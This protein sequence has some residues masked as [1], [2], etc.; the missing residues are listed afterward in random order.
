MSD[1][2][3][4]HSSPS[5]D[6]SA[7]SGGLASI[8]RAFLRLTF[9][10]TLLSLAGVFTGGV[11]LYA[12]LGESEAVRQQTAATVWPYV[13]LTIRDFVQDDE[14]AFSL[15]FSNSGVGP[16]KM[17]EM[18]LLIDG[19]VYRD[20][21][22]VLTAFLDEEFAQSV[23]YGRSD[24]TGRVL[25]PGETLTSF[26]TNDRVVVEGMQAGI[27]SGRV[28]L[29]YCYCSIFDDCWHAEISALGGPEPAPVELC[30]VYGED[31]FR[32]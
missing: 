6:A 25:S 13:Q 22:A 11:A 32:N 5:G 15:E 30:P 12:A 26:Q 7:P 23:R 28:S 9:W 19:E 14:A 29:S 21:R 1:G 18:Q 3:K 8:E 20:W 27:Y 2:Q 31:R 24:V 17:R 4:E 16:A 10:Q